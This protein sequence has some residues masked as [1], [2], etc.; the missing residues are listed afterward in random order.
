MKNEKTVVENIQAK[1]WKGK[2]KIYCQKASRALLSHD[3]CDNFKQSNILVT[4]VSKRK[5]IRKGTGK[6]I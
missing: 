3:L 6:H 1:T 4:R 2:K 5:D